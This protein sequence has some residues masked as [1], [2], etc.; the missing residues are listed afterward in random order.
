MVFSQWG[1]L[2]WDICEAYI[3]ACIRTCVIATRTLVLRTSIL[4]TAWHHE[5]TRGYLIKRGLTICTRRA[6]CTTRWLCIVLRI[7]THRIMIYFSGR[8][9]LGEAKTW[10]SKHIIKGTRTRYSSTAWRTPP[11]RL[12]G[13]FVIPVIPQA[14]CR[15]ARLERIKGTSRKGSDVGLVLGGWERPC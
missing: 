2:R 5:P 8:C 11:A 7:F 4:W 14:G 9:L 12:Q 3:H 10:G 15:V 6:T 13:P 1:I